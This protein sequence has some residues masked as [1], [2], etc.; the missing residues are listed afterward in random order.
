MHYNFVYE[1]RHAFKKQS[2]FVQILYAD[3]VEAYYKV[4]IPKPLIKLDAYST[5]VNFSLILNHS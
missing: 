4:S 3:L 2:S 5:V 1:E